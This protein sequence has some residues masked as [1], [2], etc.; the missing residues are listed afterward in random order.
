MNKIFYLLIL[1]ISICS[2]NPHEPV[3]LETKEQRELVSSPDD[4]EQIEMMSLKLQGKY[5]DIRSKD[6]LLF[7]KQRV[8]KGIKR[9]THFMIELDYKKESVFPN[10]NI[11]TLF[12]PETEYWSWKFKNDTLEM[13]PLLF[14]NRDMFYDSFG[15][16]ITF[17]RLKE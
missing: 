7:G 9:F 6:T 13:A 12:G 8:F 5:L 4:T 14:N 1:I 3:N 2:C 16:K 10:M 11:V 15:Q 17:L